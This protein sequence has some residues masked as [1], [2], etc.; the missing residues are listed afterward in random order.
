MCSFLHCVSLLYLPR[1][2]FIEGGQVQLLAGQLR[3][4]QL[5]S[6]MLVSAQLDTRVQC[7]QVMCC[8]CHARAEACAAGLCGSDASDAQ[9]WH[10][11]L[12]SG[13][14]WVFVAET[15]LRHSVL[16]YL[17][18]LAMCAQSLALRSPSAPQHFGIFQ[19]GM[20]VPVQS[21]EELVPLWRRLYAMHSCA[22]CSWLPHA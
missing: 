15:H 9:A 18:P 11:A 19:S 10:A 7:V 8:S 21:L 17:V 14:A 4:G 20:H 13:P 22:P 16:H 6:C 5:M 12:L 1:L 3:L 2:V